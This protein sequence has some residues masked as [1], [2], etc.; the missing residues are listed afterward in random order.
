MSPLTLYSAPRLRAD[1]VT[2]EEYNADRSKY[3]FD[4]C[5]G[6][7]PEV[8]HTKIYD[9]PVSGPDGTIKV[10]LYV[11]TEDAIAAGGLKTSDGKL[12]AHVDYHGGG[13]V[14]GS[15]H[16]DDSWCRQVCQ[17]VGCIVLNVDYRMAPEHPHPVSLMDSW[18]ALKW[19]FEKADELGIDTSRVSVGGLSAGGQIAAVLALMARDE[20]GMPKLALQMLIVPAVDMRFIPIEGS[21]DPGVPYKS[22]IDNEYAPCLPLHRSRWF[23]NL[24]LGTDVGKSPHRQCV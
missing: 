8:G 3:T 5:P 7:S 1:Q 6:P 17:A 10:Q 22:Y 2:Y 23:Y 24:W 18:A 12:P 9:V 4:I 20:P 14:I 19:T 21:C 11:P 13:W 15:L 16:S